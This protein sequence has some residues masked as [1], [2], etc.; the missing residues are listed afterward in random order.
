MRLVDGLIG[1][2]VDSLYNIYGHRCDNIQELN[3]HNYILFVGD[4]LG[5]RLDLPIEET[6][7]YIVSKKLSIDYYNLSIF[8]G[9]IDIIK[10]NL[11]VWLKKYPAPK[12]IIIA[13]E[14][15]NAIVISDQNFSFIKPADLSDGIIND[16]LDSANQCGFFT[17]RQLLFS[18]LIDNSV[19][20]PVY[21]IQIENQVPAVSGKNLVN[22][23]CESTD[24]KLIAENVYKTIIQRTKMARA[25]V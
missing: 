23:Q 25:S 19:P 3:F 10:H 4:N 5:L 20:C 1:H 17:G 15:S 7:P 16:L 14:F 9:G 8:N 12:A 21:Q 11:F 18:H 2:D 24:Q 13:S 22:I 6:F